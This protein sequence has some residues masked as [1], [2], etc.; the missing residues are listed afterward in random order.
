MTNDASKQV[1]KKAEV[2]V[3]DLQNAGTNDSGT[4]QEMLMMDACTEEE[5]IPGAAVDS[6][7]TTQEEDQ[8]TKV[9]NLKK[10]RIRKQVEVAKVASSRVA[11]TGTPILLR[12]ERRAAMADSQ[13]EEALEADGEAEDGGPDH[14]AARTEAMVN[15]SI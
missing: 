12:A 3:S 8:F 6:G 15:A 7:K 1:N 4:P 5:T 9:V 13:V 2:T 14:E 10:Q 11:G